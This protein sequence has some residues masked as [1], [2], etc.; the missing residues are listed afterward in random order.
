[1]SVLR[2]RSSTTS[3]A[4]NLPFSA[5]G[6]HVHCLFWLALDAPAN[7]VH[8]RLIFK[9]S[10]RGFVSELN[11]Q[12]GVGSVVPSLLL[13]R[14]N[15]TRSFPSVPTPRRVAALLAGDGVGEGRPSGTCPPSLP[16]A[17]CMTDSHEASF[18]SRP[19][20][21]PPSAR[22]TPGSRRRRGAS[23]NAVL[24]PRS[25]LRDRLARVTGAEHSSGRCGLL[26]PRS[27]SSWPTA[28]ALGV[29]HGPVLL[30]PLTERLVYGAEAGRPA[31]TRHRYAA[32]IWSLSSPPPPLAD[33]LGNGAGRGHPSQPCSPLPS[34]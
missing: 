14:E 13:L 29:S 9:H 4:M 1:M 3:N 8:L 20:R 17:D 5:Y 22:S 28:P 19:C 16:L 11:H 7:S 6:P 18:S 34:G 30:F 32:S 2:N 15:A 24:S 31:G 10:L 26:H 27:P 21:H 23:F 25:A 12:T 33:R